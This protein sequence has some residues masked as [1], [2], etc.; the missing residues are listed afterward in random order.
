VHGAAVVDSAAPGPLLVRAGADFEV[1]AAAV[2]ERPPLV[3][4]RL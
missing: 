2:D 1:R 3:Q 4:R